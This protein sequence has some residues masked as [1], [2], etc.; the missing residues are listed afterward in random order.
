MKTHLVAAI[1]ALLLI[2]AVGFAAGAGT[3]GTA[4]R[5]RVG[6]YD[7]R[8]VAFSYF[9]SDPV[10]RQ[11]DDL[12]KRAKAAKDAGHAAA[13][14]EIDRQLVVLQKQAHLQVFS[15]APANEAMAALAPQLPALK[16]ELG[17]ARLVSKWD[18]K[19][20]KSIPETDR[21]DV[22]DRLVRE[23]LTPSEKQRKTI[24]TLKTGKPLPLWQARLMTAFGKG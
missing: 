6:V 20:L 16:Q 1:A 7:S 9:W 12:V 11:R 19:A 8:V 13:L 23:F 14:K 3:P 10:G 21:V 5:E 2:A 24:E 4:T 22:T 17:I 15:S 18:A